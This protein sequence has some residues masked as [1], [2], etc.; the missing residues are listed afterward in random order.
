[1]SAHSTEEHGVLL[2]GIQS[3]R[4]EQGAQQQTEPDASS[5]PTEMRFGQ[6][7]SLSPAAKRYRLEKQARKE[8]TA[9]ATSV[10]D[11]NEDA[12]VESAARVSATVALQDD[13]ASPADALLGGAD[14]S[15][16]VSGSTFCVEADVTGVSDET[17]TGFDRATGPACAEKGA[18][19]PSV[20]EQE[21][22]RHKQPPQAMPYT[23]CEDTP[24]QPLPMEDGNAAAPPVCL[25]I[26]EEGAVASPPSALAVT[27]AHL[28]QADKK[29]ASGVTALNSGTLGGNSAP[30]CHAEGEVSS[31]TEAEP[32]TD[33]VATTKIPS[34]IPEDGENGCLPPSRLSE[35][36][37]P[38]PSVAAVD[39]RP[40]AAGK[41]LT[42]ADDAAPQPSMARSS[43]P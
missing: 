18:A 10:I 24:A 14:G 8:V 39:E 11:L 29:T 33:N 16:D 36:A 23:E 17:L 35:A 37:T 1:M 32:T 27:P 30:R 13:L 26:D 3:Q 42:F 15:V 41:H 6:A 5:V 9:D 21:T 28:S 4:H 25:S 43:P 34:P 20:H 38:P 7:A 2:P 40:K 12:D 22:L 19:T 31:A